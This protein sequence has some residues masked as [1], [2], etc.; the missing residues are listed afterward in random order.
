MQLK[1]AI[2]IYFFMCFSYLFHLLLD[3]VGRD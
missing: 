1:D 2:A 3:A